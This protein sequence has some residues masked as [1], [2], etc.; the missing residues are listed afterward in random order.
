MEKYKLLPDAPYYIKDENTMLVESIN[1]ELNTNFKLF[2]TSEGDLALITNSQV[3]IGKVAEILKK[4]G[5]FIYLADYYDLDLFALIIKK[6]NIPLR[7][8]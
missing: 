4:Q 7:K 1:S 5:Y 6:C 3:P 2:S 8:D